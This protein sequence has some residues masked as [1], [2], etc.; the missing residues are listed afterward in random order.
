MHSVCLDIFSMPN[1][2]GIDFDSI[3][4]CVDRLSGWI[5]ACPTQKLGLTAEKAAHLIMD[6]GWDFFG[7]PTT[8][9]SDMGPQFIGQWW[10]TMCARLGIH[11][12]YSPPHR[13]RANGR[14]ERAGQQLLSILKRLHLQGSLNWFQALPRTIMLHHHTVG[15]V[16]FSHHQIIF[17]RHRNPL[18]SLHSIEDL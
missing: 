14:A 5:T 13:P 8:V 2:Q 10:K 11:Q 4:L 6:R 3:L 16:K 12:T 17:I 18:H 1:W 15:E 7:I 9:H